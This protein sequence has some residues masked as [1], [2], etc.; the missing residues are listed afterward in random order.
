MPS[1]RAREAGAPIRGGNDKGGTNF[2]SKAG[3]TVIVGLLGW[4]FYEFAK[5]TGFQA[6]GFGYQFP[7]SYGVLGLGAITL[8]V[9]WTQW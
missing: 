6:S 5:D 9:I 8:Y 4:F 2:I 3:S 1:P 7:L